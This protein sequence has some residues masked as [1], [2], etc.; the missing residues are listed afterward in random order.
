MGN[1][2][3]TY[4][5]HDVFHFRLISEPTVLKEIESNIPLLT[6]VV[7]TTPKPNVLK[8]NQENEIINNLFQTNKNA[9][10]FHNLNLITS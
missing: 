3:D 4:V 10:N 9:P 2:N 7:L 8:I 5:N 6:E 1:E